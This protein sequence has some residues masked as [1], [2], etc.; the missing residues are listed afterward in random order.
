M[1]YKRGRHDEVGDE[2]N[3]KS[4]PRVP[5]TPMAPVHN[6]AS[7]LEAR[8]GHFGGVREVNCPQI[9]QIQLACYVFLAQT[10]DENVCQKNSELLGQGNIL[11][12]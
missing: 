8:R 10:T 11:N 4:R 9:Q 5:K 2:I 7:Q 6:S 12:G 3:E 1:C